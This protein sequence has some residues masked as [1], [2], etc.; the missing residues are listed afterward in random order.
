MLSGVFATS[1][2][3]TLKPV[4]KKMEA[5]KEH[6]QGPY[7]SITLPTIAANGYWPIIPLGEFKMGSVVVS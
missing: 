4:V 2:A 5:I 6:A 1:A 3:K 7:P